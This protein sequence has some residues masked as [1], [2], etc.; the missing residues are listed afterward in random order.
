MISALK[1]QP[2]ASV[3]LPPFSFPPAG[4]QR[5]T[6]LVTD[7]TDGIGTAICKKMADNGH[8]VATTYRN[9]EGARAWQS[10][11]EKEGYLFFIYKCDVADFEESRG[12]AR[13]VMEDLGPIDILISSAETVTHSAIDGMLA[14]G[15]GRVININEQANRAAEAGVCG[16]TKALVREIAK[17]GVTIN[18]VAADMLRSAPEDV[19]HVVSFL[20]AE[21]S[22][23]ITGANIAANGAHFMD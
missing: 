9:A 4:L 20:A 14:R 8:F 22:G 16:F 19:A 6:V 5:R 10:R 23:F 7:G 3:S 2:L 12:L 18:T 17:R 1:T 15:F 11:M 21:E 13:Q